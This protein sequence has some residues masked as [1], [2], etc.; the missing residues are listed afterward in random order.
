MRIFIKPKIKHKNV[1]GWYNGDDEWREKALKCVISVHKSHFSSN[2]EVRLK[3]ASFQRIL[4]EHLKKV[5]EN[6]RQLIKFIHF[7]I[8]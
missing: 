7:N 5:D 8:L 6:Q 3:F 1:C 4:Y 2:I